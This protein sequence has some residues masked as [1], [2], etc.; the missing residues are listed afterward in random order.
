[1]AGLEILKYG[2]STTKLQPKNITSPKVHNFRSD[3]DA[4]SNASWVKQGAKLLRDSLEMKENNAPKIHTFTSIEQLLR[5]KIGLMTCQE[6]YDERKKDMDKL[7]IDAFQM[8]EKCERTHRRAINKLL[9]AISGKTDT[10][11]IEILTRSKQDLEESTSQLRAEIE[12][13]VENASDPDDTTMTKKEMFAIATKAIGSGA[14]AG[15]AAYIASESHA[16]IKAALATTVVASVVL[17]LK[18]YNINP[19]EYIMALISKASR[20]PLWAA[21]TVIQWNVYK[22]ISCKFLESATLKMTSKAMFLTGASGDVMREYQHVEIDDLNAETSS[23]IMQA[24]GQTIRAGLNDPENQQ[25]IAD[26]GGKTLG[27]VGQSIGLPPGITSSMTG[28]VTAVASGASV[29]SPLYEA[30]LLEKSIMNN[31]KLLGELLD[32]QCF[33]KLIPH[34]QFILN[35]ICLLQAQVSTKG[36]IGA[37]VKP[38]SPTAEPVSVWERVWTTLKNM[39]PCTEYRSKQFDVTRFQYQYTSTQMKRENIKSFQEWHET[40]FVEKVSPLILTRFTVKYETGTK[41]EEDYLDEMT[42]FKENNYKHSVCMD[43][44]QMGIIDEDTLK[45]SKGNISDDNTK[46]NDFAGEREYS[47][48]IN[49]VIPALVAKFWTEELQNT[50]LLTRLGSGKM[51]PSAQYLRIASML[52]H[53]QLKLWF[54]VNKQL[55]TSKIWDGSNDDSYDQM[56]KESDGNTRVSADG[57]A[58]WTMAFIQDSVVQAA[59]I[60]TWYAVNGVRDLVNTLLIERDM[61]IVDKKLSSAANISNT[62]DLTY[63]LIQRMGTYREIQH[64]MAQHGDIA[65]CY[66]ME[67]FI[68]VL[69]SYIPDSDCTLRTQK[70]PNELKESTV[71][72]IATLLN[73]NRD[74]VDN[75]LTYDKNEK[76]LQSWI[77]HDTVTPPESFKRSINRDGEVEA[78]FSTSEKLTLRRYDLSSTQIRFGKQMTIANAINLPRTALQPHLTIGVTDWQDFM[79]NRTHVYW[80]INHPGMGYFK[81]DITLLEALRDLADWKLSTKPQNTYT[82]RGE[83]MLVSGNNTPQIVETYPETKQR[84]KHLYWYRPVKSLIYEE[85]NNKLKTWQRLKKKSPNDFHSDFNPVHQQNSTEKW[86]L[87]ELI[88]DGAIDADLNYRPPSISIITTWESLTQSSEWHTYDGLQVWDKYPT[89]DEHVYNTLNKAVMIPV[90]SD[91]VQANHILEQST[92]IDDLLHK[93]AK[94]SKIWEFTGSASET[95]II[96]YKEH[97][98]FIWSTENAKEIFQPQRDKQQGNKFTNK[99]EKYLYWGPFSREMDEVEY[100]QL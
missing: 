35:S 13:A 72:L 11:I 32:P 27:I 64:K 65:R 86:V 10:L 95:E 28:M 78:S 5:D 18:Y 74:T 55:W 51:P 2:R 57:T 59:K 6:T 41:N 4:T 42:F 33:L 30:M 56:K 91:L 60:G 17:Y 92:T 3:T 25:K 76:L 99:L 14:L 45:S 29:A 1:M 52:P 23:F 98:L 53:T 89:I 34:W 21:Q 88:E 58:S 63:V 54:G 20:S 84:S 40:T 48:T 73:T 26:I 68:R 49:F 62:R 71:R 93:G 46:T 16:G 47:I 12:Q 83:H 7:K 79:A 9:A 80:F 90:S 37:D 69:C 100:N 24:V 39:H 85:A 97:L 15:A 96:T 8:V 31:L 94:L 44:S 43:I 61:T 81:A 67:Q 66:C 77:N 87:G 38:P 70:N 50:H 36:S 75:T 19:V 22:K 82:S